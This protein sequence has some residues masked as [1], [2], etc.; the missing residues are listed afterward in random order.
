MKAHKIYPLAL[1]AGGSSVILAEGS[2]VRIKSSTGQ[3]QIFMDD[4]GPFGPLDPGQGFRDFPYKRL[5]I[6]DVSGSANN[7]Q[8]IVAD[9][10]F[11][12]D[13]I[14]GTVAVVDGGKARTQANQAFVANA[15]I[16]GFAAN[17]GHVQLWNP[18]TAR[19]AIVKALWVSALSDGVMDVCEYNVALASLNAAP[20]SKLMG[21]AT[22][23]MQNRSQANAALLG[24]VLGSISV[25]ANI[26]QFVT[27]QEPI[28]VEPNTGCLIHHSAQNV[29]LVC[30]FEYYEE[31][32]T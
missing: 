1:Q 18:S 26:E 19:R 21:G 27:L 12:D 7:V 29:Q 4:I 13:T 14:T 25:K 15:Q 24:N 31:A 11:V 9:R 23:V 28:S 6:Q 5:V 20:K 10:T 30:A 17:Y 32:V 8:V 2:Y 22:S 16:L 3:V